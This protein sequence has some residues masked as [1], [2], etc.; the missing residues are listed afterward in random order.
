MG[1]LPTAQMDLP[2]PSLP[3]PGAASDA[4]AVAAAAPAASGG[5]ALAPR[6]AEDAPLFVV[7]N[8]RSGPRRGD[9]AAALIASTLRDA[10][11]EFSLL[12]VQ[13]GAQVLAMA[14]EAATRAARATGVVVAAGGDGTLNAVA[15]QAHAAGLPF[16][17]LPQGTFNYFGREHRIP[18]A[19][20][21][22]LQLL[23]RAQPQPVQ[24]GEVN[25]RLFLVNA[26]MG[27]YPAVLQEREAMTKEHGRHRW[28]ALWAGVRTM[29][30]DRRRLVLR[31]EC[32]GQPR[33]VEA[34][35][36]FVGNNRLQL[37]M[38]GVPEADV[39]SQRELAALWVRPLDTRKALGVLWGAAL[40]RLA[41]A[42]AVERFAFRRLEVQSLSGASRPRRL[43]VAID[44][45][46]CSLQTPLVF[47]PSPQPLWLMCEPPAVANASGERDR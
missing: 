16:A 38:L 14:R 27:L 18:L 32:D 6:V 7:L 24:V 40:G 45:E 43:Q 20:E 31:M 13:R 26:S 39:V 46:V 33:L 1:A 47:R 36:V 35:T 21:E 12:Q 5:G 44:G 41:Q 34:S 11:R 29:L 19:L 2:L 3:L 10:G 9:E 30:R 4:P 22:A 8:R 15:Q 42:D 17:A 37:E 28:V 25:G 23:L